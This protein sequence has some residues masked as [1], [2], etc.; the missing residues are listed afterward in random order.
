MGITD[1]KL[2]YCHGVA[3][4][5]VD[6]KMSTLEYNNRTVYDWFNNTFTVDCGNLALY[7]PPITIGGRPSP[8]KRSQYA[9]DLLPDAISVA[10]EYY[11]IT[12][13]TPSDFPDLLPTDDTNTFHVVKKYMPLRFR[14]NVGY[15]CRK[16]GRKYATKRQGSIAPHALIKTRYFI[17]FIGF[18]GL[19]QRQGLASW[20]INILC[21]NV[22]FDCCVCLPSIL[23][24]TCWTCFVL[25]FFLFH[26]SLPLIYHMSDIIDY[27]ILYW[28]FYCL[29]SC[30]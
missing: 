18:P 14:L 5:N 15:C 17:L 2:L 12:L 6:K 26:W 20:N 27:F 4:V 30:D 21:H 9:P 3:E 13:T 11:V 1:W 23:Y 10:S 25:V 29:D 16:Y 19:F 28:V 22:L 7:L 24:F 8:Q